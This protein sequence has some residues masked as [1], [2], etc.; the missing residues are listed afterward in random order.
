VSESNVRGALQRAHHHNWAQ[1][2]FSL[3][4]YTYARVGAWDAP[5]RLAEPVD[6]TIFFAG[7]ATAGEGE[8]GTVH[9]AIQSGQRAAKAIRKGA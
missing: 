7:E 3:G 2:P 6:D 1:D 5:A 9:G 4:A 8:L